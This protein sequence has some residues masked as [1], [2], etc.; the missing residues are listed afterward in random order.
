MCTLKPE[1][2][3]WYSESHIALFCVVFSIRNERGLIV[4]YTATYKHFIGLWQLSRSVLTCGGSLLAFEQE[5][6]CQIMQANMV[7]LLAITEPVRVLASFTLTAWATYVRDDYPVVLTVLVIDLAFLTMCIV[8]TWFEEYA[9]AATCVLATYNVS[10][11][12]FRAIEGERRT[13]KGGMRCSCTK[14]S[15]FPCLPTPVI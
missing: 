2:R 7:Q 11:E 10:S 3:L 9:R 13:L 1:L 4:A 6:M 12:R 15:F 5:T 8:C 14:R